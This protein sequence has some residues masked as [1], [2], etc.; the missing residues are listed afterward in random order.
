MC[1]LKSLFLKLCWLTLF[2]GHFMGFSQDVK[3][4]KESMDRLFQGLRSGE[5]KVLI[6]RYTESMGSSFLS[7]REKTLIDSLFLE[8][9]NLHVSMDPELKNFV[10]CVGSFY[11]RNEKANLL[12]W[13]EG[14]TDVLAGNERK[15]MAVRNYIEDTYALACEKALVVTPNYKWFVRGGMVWHSGKPLSVSFEHS[16][17]IC[18]TRKDSILIHETSGS[19]VLGSDWAEGKGGKVKWNLSQEEMF[20]DLSVYRIDLR[21]SGYTADSVLFHYESRYDSPIPGRLKDYAL[22]YT[23]N[24]TTPYPEF[25]SYTKDIRIKQLFEDVSFCGGITYTGLKLSGIGSEDQPAKIRIARNDTIS[26]EFSSLQFNIDTNRIMSGRSGMVIEMDSGEIVHPD[27]NLLYLV[28]A[29]TAVVKRISEQSLHVLFKDTYHR[30]LFDMEEIIWPVD[31]NYMEMRMSSRSGLFKATI[32]S[33]NYFSDNVYDNLQGLDEINPLNGLLKC[34]LALQSDIFTVADY[35]AFM[36]KPADQ[37]RKQ[38]ILLSYSD[39][40]DYNET[41]DE[42]RL[43]QRLYDY[44]KCRVGKQDYDNIR[45]ASHPQNSRVNAYLDVRNYNLSIQGVERFSISDKRNIFVE[46]S[47]KKVVIMKN[48]DMEFNGKLN[49]GMFDM[50]GNNLFF[51][52]EN[53]AITLPKVDSTS[54]YLAG[55]N[56]HLRGEK[57]KSLI[58]NITGEIVIDKPG[59]KS[60]KKEDPGFPVLNSSRE[61]YVYFDDPDIQKGAYKRDSFYY[62]IEPYVIEGINDADKFRYA[63]DGTLVSNIVSPIRDT[64]RLMEDNA[65]GLTYRTPAAGVELYGKGRLCSEITL[66]RSG[67][68]AAGS[69][70]MNKSVFQSDTILMLPDRMLAHTQEIKV[71][72]VKGCRPGAIGKDIMV[73]YLPVDGNLLAS[74]KSIPFMLYEGRV[75]HEG[76]LLVY[77]KLLDANGKLH[78][79]DATLRSELFHI[80]D[81]NIRSDKTALGISSISN[82]NIRLNTSNVRAEIDLIA[83]KGKFINNEDAN[84]AEF[85]SSRYICSFESFTWYMKEAYLNIGIEDREQLERI[86]KVEDLSTLPVGRINRFVSTDRLTDSLNFMAPLARYDL[87]TGN[88]DCHWI[89]HINLANGRFYPRLGDIF[90]EPDG[91]IRELTGGRLLCDR[92]D[93]TRYMTDVTLDI[94]G[95]NS[96]SGSGNYRYVSEEKKANILLF[97]KIGVDTS[98][99]VYAKAELKENSSLL[100]NNG[101]RFKGNIVLH[102]KKPDLF[103]QGYVKMTADSTYLKHEWL[104]VN[105]YLRSEHISIPVMVENKNDKKQRLYNGIFLCTD[106]TFKPYGC[107]LSKRLFYKDD[108]LAE[109]RGKLEWRGGIRQYVIT[110]TLNDRYYHF[111]YDPET[112]AVTAFSNLNL[113]LKIPGMSQKAAGDISYSLK[114]EELKISNILYAMDF[115]LLPKM[116]NILWKELTDK[117][118]KALNVNAGQAEKIYEII[119]RKSMA[120]WEKQ[121]KRVRTVPD[122]LHQQW[123]FDSLNLSWNAKTNSYIAKGPVRVMSIA[124]KPV[125]KVMNIKLELLRKRSDNQFFMYIYD[126]QMWYYFEYSDR[127]LYTLSSNTE[128]NDAVKLEKAEK[129]VI[130]TADKQELYTITLCPDSKKERFLGRLK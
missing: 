96:F 125:Q 39:F 54:M 123:V 10:A 41:R 14:L 94:K 29:R 120:M 33:F 76:T 99:L 68:T 56:K 32:E 77:E 61:S 72:A 127:S 20:A 43:K 71:E 57:I 66:N 42:I 91:K 126:E 93:T 34:S 95:R 11:S 65:L 92:E 30:I 110:D 80:E 52:Y 81:A 63:F 31:S 121:D 7:D 3:V 124:G 86:W 88:I 50:Y 2:M 83:N 38:V 60:G 103:F 9:Q 22:K 78:L 37:L 5:R 16:A 118:M 108:L 35:T 62:V 36:K 130:R 53:Y 40:V 45:F 100:L 106:K 97:N 85:S 69:V 59:N 13:I 1:V 107:F 101:F 79:E 82:K 74:S 12:V 117:K 111:R 90:I 98:R 28:P 122:S 129:K 44:T 17:L 109:G 21:S 87:K 51:S 114:E 47:D 64:L 58:R 75:R 8:L 26:M 89:N 67:F 27:I 128:Y 73:E 84:Q 25:S 116:E 19:Y 4:M 23:R 104:A 15:R 112:A 18:T 48:R 102:S 115:Q 70:D 119:G 113:D 49:A 24:S 105:D 6:E 46:P 55:K